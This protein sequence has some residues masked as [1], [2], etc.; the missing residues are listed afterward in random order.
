MLWVNTSVALFSALALVAIYISL[1]MYT[2]RPMAEASST[3]AL[4]W[5]QRTQ[6][7]QESIGGVRDLILDGT[8]PHF[9]L[10]YDESERQ[11][12][13][14]QRLTNFLAAAPRFLVEAFGFVT[15]ISIALW[16]LSRGEA[17]SS[18]V[19]TLG[20]M[21]VGAQRLL[22]LL[23]QSYAAIAGLNSNRQAIQDVADLLREQPS[24]PVGPSI[25]QLSFSERILFDH[26]S[27][28]YSPSKPDVLREL[29]LEI[30]RGDHIGIFGPSGG[31]KSTFMDILLGLQA[32][33]S[34]RILVDETPLD[35]RTLTSWHQKVA[36]VPQNVFLADCSIAENIAFGVPRDQIDMVRLERAA[37][38]AQVTRFSE[39]LPLGLWTIVG[40]RGTT[41]SGG[42][43]QRIG[44]AR[45]LYKRAQLLV[46]DEITSA[47]DS[48]TEQE[49]VRTIRNLPTDRTIVVIAHRLTTLAQCNRLFEL[50]DSRLHERGA[51]QL[52]FSV[53]RCE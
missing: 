46:L 13:D 21:A 39:G 42:Q 51:E 45:A 15:L 7:A 25:H 31:G 33:T 19:P 50:K 49:I 41:L 12:R 30:R 2:R 40:E 26:V 34:G 35:C 6:L 44:I 11:L 29:S 48:E 4:A 18:I 3:V 27:F 53:V 17:L 32:P 14:A 47:L 8:A 16:L 37:E 1:T 24:L 43:K 5:R 28:A 52:K 22:P 38:G 20:A 9:M 36:H 10:L 23:Q